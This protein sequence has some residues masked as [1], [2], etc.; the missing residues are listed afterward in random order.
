MNNKQ[1]EIQKAFET[2]KLDDRAS[3]KEVEL[4]YEVLTRDKKISNQQLQKYRSAFEILMNEIFLDVDTEQDSSIDTNDSNSD[5]YSTH[6][7]K[8]YFDLFNLSNYCKNIFGLKFWTE[9]D[10]KDAFYRENEYEFHEVYFFLY[11]H[12][13]ISESFLISMFIDDMMKMVKKDKT[14]CKNYIRRITKEGVVGR[15]VVSENTM[16][17]LTFILQKYAESYNYNICLSGNKL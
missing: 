2:L 9:K 10:L 16:D 7:N 15:M 5:V 17:S 1:K 4:A 8:N 11:H 13:G 3:K 14:L 12:R 6:V